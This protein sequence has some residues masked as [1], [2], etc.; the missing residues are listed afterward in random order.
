MD[1]GVDHYKALCQVARM[2]GAC[3]QARCPND[4][5]GRPVEC[6]FIMGVGNAA[7]VDEIEVDEMDAELG[8]EG[9]YDDVRPAVR[10]WGDEA[11]GHNPVRACRVG[12]ASNPG[13]R[14][15]VVQSGDSA[16]SPVPTDV[17]AP[18]TM[19]DTPTSAASPVDTLLEVFDGMDKR[20][21]RGGCAGTRVH[22]RWQATGCE[23][24]TACGTLPGRTCAAH[25]LCSTAIEKDHSTLWSTAGASYFV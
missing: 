13:P 20:D 22:K 15:G 11:A 17:S 9:G 7:N 4:V 1:G 5:Q 14:G 23:V 19:A 6:C 12:E 10:V 3:S 8:P 18:T 16:C 24:C 21:G 2:S 25:A